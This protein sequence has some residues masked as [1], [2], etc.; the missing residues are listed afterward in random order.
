MRKTLLMLI[1]TLT[2]SSCIEYSS[3][4]RFGQVIKFSRKGLFF[5]TW[6]G[7]MNIGGTTSSN[8]GGLVPNTW[9][10]SIDESRKRG[11]NVARLVD[12][13]LKAAATGERVEVK[14]MQEMVTAPWR[15]STPYLIQDVKLQEKTS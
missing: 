4:S 13:L 11:E 1:I 12:L 7:Q 8:D 10:F 5:K 14:Y 6:E 3:G 9:M 2:L 15:S